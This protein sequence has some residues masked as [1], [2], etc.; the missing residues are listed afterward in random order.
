MKK[1][2]SAGRK[3]KSMPQVGR[4]QAVTGGGEELVRMEPLLADRALPLVIRPAV[5]GVTEPADPGTGR[6]SSAER[7]ATSSPP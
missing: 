1:I 4:R 3:A 2:G 5:D 7:R 6:P